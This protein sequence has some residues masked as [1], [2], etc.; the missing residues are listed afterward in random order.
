M[1]LEEFSALRDRAVVTL[2]SLN[3]GSYPRESGF[4]AKCDDLES[5]IYQIYSAGVSVYMWAA[6][7]QDS[8][9]DKDL[10]SVHNKLKD[11]GWNIILTQDDKADDM[12]LAATDAPKQLSDVDTYINTAINLVLSKRQ[13]EKALINYCKY[14]AKIHG[15]GH[16]ARAV[17]FVEGVLSKIEDYNKE[18]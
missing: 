8:R 6:D 4:S 13:L 10:D 5:L 9:T 18:S 14:D 1:T 11:D 2:Y 12:D 15:D 16:L 3:D 7:V 17:S